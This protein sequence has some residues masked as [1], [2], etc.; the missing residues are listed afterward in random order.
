MSNAI[1]FQSYTNCLNATQFNLR[2]VGVGGTGVPTYL[3]GDGGYVTASGTATAT[4]TGSEWT[5]TRTS[6]GQLVLTS[7]NPWPGLY[8]AD[9]GLF[10]ATADA[11]NTSGIQ[12]PA[13]PTQNSTTG[14]W[15]I[16][17]NVYVAATLTDLATTQQMWLQIVMRNSLTSP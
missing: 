7:V 13:V 15:T 17:L 1:Y 11:T 12:F 9:G 14:I 5:L 2:F 8:S 3:E 10:L 6:T 4:S 16:N